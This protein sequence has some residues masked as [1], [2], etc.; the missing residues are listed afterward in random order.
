MIRHTHLLRGF[1]LTVAAVLLTACGEPKQPAQTTAQTVTEPAP[2]T[3]ESPAVEAEAIEIAARGKKSAFQIVYD[4]EDAASGTHAVRILNAIKDGLGVNLTLR[5][6]YLATQETPCEILVGADRRADCA[7]LTETLSENEYAI[8]TVREDDKTKIIIAYKGVYALMSAVDNFIEDYVDTA[9]G[10]VS[11]PA[12]LDIRA[13]CNGTDVMI[14]SSIPQLRDPCVLVEDGVYYAY[15]TGWVCWKN[16]TGNLANGWQ[17]LGVVAEKPAEATNNYWAPEV[18]KY[19][20]AYYMFTTYY[21]SKTNHRGC[22]ILKSDSPEGPFREITN[23]H[24]TPHDWDSID[25]TFYVDPDGQPWMIF[26]H[27]WTSTDDGIGR[28]AAAKLSDDLTRFISE[29]V[30]LFRADDPSWAKAQVTDGCWMYR[31]ADGQLLMLWSNSD[32][33]G[34]CVGIAR[35]AD[36]RVDGEWT[37]DRDLLY[38]KNMT[39]RYDGGHGMLFTDTDG[40]MYLSIHSPNNSS[41]GRKET[42]VFIRVRETADSRLVWDLQGE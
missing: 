12:D 28:M 39:G 31:C 30:E 17:S 16:T 38:S 23:G 8:R 6:D 13:K 22:T 29:P 34:Y 42:P 27:E 15:G 9:V 36:G 26:V 41:A 21:S 7:A 14:T 19:N 10:T 20:G 35:S 11:I 1:C 37:Q 18:H 3:T 24:I 2:I 33:A 32:S 25:G 40:Q 4:T 5:T